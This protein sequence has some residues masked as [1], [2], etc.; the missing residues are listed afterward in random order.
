M[1][2]PGRDRRGRLVDRYRALGVERG[3]VVY[4]AAD[5]G[6]M[7]ESARDDRAALLGDHLA[8]LRELVGPDGTIVVP[9]ASTN[10]CNTTTVFDPDTT[11][12]HQMGAFAEFVRLQPDARRSFHPFWS[13]SALGGGAGALV[14]DVSRHAFGVGSVWSRLVEAGALALH[15]GVHPRLSISVIHHIELVTGVPYRYTKEFMHP[16]KRGDKVSVEPFYHFVCY[17]DADIRRDGNRRIY[18]HYAATGGVRTAAEARGTIWSFPLRDFY[19][20]TRALLARD[21]Y[22]WVEREPA[23]RP[24]QR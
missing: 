11:P 20:A 1:S 21:L 14:D 13:V 22:A 18:D 9:T 12:S 24:Y 4:V 15:V 6:P 2:E 10:L 5:F 17:L 19:D 16:V 3:R 7:R 23:V 8:A